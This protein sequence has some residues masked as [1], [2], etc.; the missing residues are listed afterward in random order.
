MASD[1]TPEDI[2]GMLYKEELLLV[3]MLAVADDKATLDPR[4]VQGVIDDNTWGQLTLLLALPDDARL[5]L[6]VFVRSNQFVVA[7]LNKLK[8]WDHLF[9]KKAQVVRKFN[10]LHKLACELAKEIEQCD[11][12]LRSDASLCLNVV[13]DRRRS[14]G[15]QTIN[16]LAAAREL[17]DYLEE[18]AYLAKSLPSTSALTGVLREII[19]GL[20]D[21]VFKH[22]GTSLRRTSQTK[23][24]G[25]SYG[26]RCIEFSHEVLKLIWCDSEPPKKGAVD[27]AIKDVVKKRRPVGR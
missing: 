25:T 13:G 20:D 17:S 8:E 26:Q 23:Q 16:P 18:A 15:G 1:D 12:N 10:H 5:H 21:F 11:S 14:N 3:S 2:L 19:G 24:G 9:E 6:S 4:L 22:T 7:N 27:D